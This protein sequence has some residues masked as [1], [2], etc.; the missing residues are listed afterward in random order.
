MKAPCVM[1]SKQV[2]RPRKS[3]ILPL[4]G[5]ARCSIWG[6]AH[7]HPDGDLKDGLGFA[8]LGWPTGTWVGT[9][10]HPWTTMTRCLPGARSSRTRRTSRFEFVAALMLGRTRP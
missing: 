3:E 8:D 4:G 2:L 6:S 1:A 10:L 5:S 9:P 7:G